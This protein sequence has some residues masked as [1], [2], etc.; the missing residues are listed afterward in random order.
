[1]WLNWLCA[2][3]AFSGP[4]RTAH[5][6]C[7]G[8]EGQRPPA[9]I[10][11]S[12]GVE[13]VVGL[14]EPIIVHA[15]HPDQRPA[16]HAR[17]HG[18]DDQQAEHCHGCAC[19]QR[20]GE[21][22]TDQGTEGNDASRRWRSYSSPSQPH[23]ARDNTSAKV[24]M[25]TRTAADRPSCPEPTRQSPTGRNGPPLHSAMPRAGANRSC[26]PGH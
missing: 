15:Q 8:G 2:T 24:A 11:E 1:M 3:A 19:A 22:A 10:C 26:A 5:Q 20:L 6:R 25:A 12:P 13:V 18:Q 14:P 7:S 17:H 23:K 21:C 16:E 9:S 4:Q